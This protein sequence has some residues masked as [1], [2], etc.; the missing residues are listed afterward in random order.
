MR[1]REFTLLEAVSDPEVVKTQ[2]KLRDLGYDLGPYGPK[3]DGVDGIVGPYTQTAMDAYAKGL[4]PKDAPKPNPQAVQ[5][6]NQEIGYVDH[7]DGSM[8]VNGRITTKFGAPTSLGPHPGLDI[9]AVTGTPV[10]SPISGVVSA[11]G[12]DNTRGNW[13]QVDGNGVAHRFLHLSQIH[14]S[15]GDKVS[16]GQT[17]GLVG[18]TGYSTGPHLH[19][20]KYVAGR[21]TDPTSA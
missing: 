13:L 2:E 19:W 8:P 10:K 18:S 11:V 3:G 7:G 5:K 16:S 15:K 1:A 17:V 6:Y 14:A 12:S 9:A 4:S 21:L 20:E